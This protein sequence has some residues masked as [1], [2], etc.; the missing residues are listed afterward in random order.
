MKMTKTLAIAKREFQS[1]FDSPIAYIVI[2]TFQLVSGW[3]VF[4]ILFAP[5]RNLADLRVF[6]TP[7]FFSPS[8]LLLILAAAITMR[9]IAEERKV[10]TIELLTSMPIR[11][12]EVITGKFLAAVGLVSIGLA[13]TG[14]YALS[15]D[16]VGDLDWGP[17]ISGYLGILLFTASLCAIG[18]M[19]STWTKNQIIA[20][21]ASLMIS[22]T[23]YYI[24]W[25]HLFLPDFIAPVV[26]FVSISAHLENMAR[27]VIDGRDVV[28]YLSLTGGALFLAERSLSRQH[29]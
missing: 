2:V 10:G 25:L 16:L 11:D 21:I 14:F 6:F 15:I 19:C 7:T 3:M 22:A 28:Y 9:L 20:F 8:L 12:C 18:L 26:E 27:G 23:L 13:S 17:V 1:Y 5:N 24:H 29:A 4:S